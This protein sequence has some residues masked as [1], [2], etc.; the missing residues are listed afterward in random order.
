MPILSRQFS[1]RLALAVRLSCIVA[2]LLVIAFAA[3]AC[4]QAAR[5]CACNFPRIATSLKHCK[6]FHVENATS[7]VEMSLIYSPSPWVFAGL[8]RVCVKSGI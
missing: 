3:H 4:L 2:L 7:A 1:R 8:A 5:P 6:V